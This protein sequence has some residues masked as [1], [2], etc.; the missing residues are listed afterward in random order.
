[1]LV[2]IKID[3]LYTKYCEIKII[4]TGKLD[5]TCDNI[6]KLLMSGKVSRNSTKVEPKFKFQIIK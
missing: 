1:M 5:E 6:D 3:E 2:T 4:D